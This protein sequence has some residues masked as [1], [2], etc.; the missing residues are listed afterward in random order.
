MP[1]HLANQKPIKA[2]EEVNMFNIESNWIE[3]IK[4]K[5]VGGYLNKDIVDTEA[6]AYA[7]VITTENKKFLIFT[8]ENHEEPTQLKGLSVHIHHEVISTLAEIGF[9]TQDEAREFEAESQEIKK[10]KG[11]VR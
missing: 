4:S 1:K 7:T 10:S 3:G 2:Q 5:E 6:V 9:L 8:D 11:M